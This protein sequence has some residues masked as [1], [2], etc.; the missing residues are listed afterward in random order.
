[1]WT[2][3]RRQHHGRKTL[4][5]WRRKVVC[6][7][8]SRWGYLFLYREREKKEREEGALAVALLC[9][10][11]L[12]VLL[13]RHVY[14]AVYDIVGLFI[15]CL[16]VCAVCTWCCMQGEDVVDYDIGRTKRQQF[17]S[18]ALLSTIFYYNVFRSLAQLYLL[19]PPVYWHMYVTSL[20]ADG[21]AQRLEEILERKQ[22]LVQQTLPSLCVYVC[23][24]ACLS[25]CLMMM[26]MMMMM[27]IFNRAALDGPMDMFSVFLFSGVHCC[28]HGCC[29][30]TFWQ[31]PNTLK[32]PL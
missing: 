14:A 16:L 23:L 22:Q 17:H 24:Y 6:C 13:C 15:Y 8:R 19:C 27:M 4:S 21:Y 30:A 29:L 11:V 9:C 5:C 2:V 18:T 3:Y 7:S 1:M 32:I 31:Q 10:S 26:M 12:V 25:V 28:W 20:W